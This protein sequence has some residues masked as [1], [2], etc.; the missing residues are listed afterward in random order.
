MAI[1]GTQLQPGA[2]FPELSLK[3]MDGSSKNFPDDLEEIWNI[4]IVLRGHW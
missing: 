2:T 1:L 3:M 4:V